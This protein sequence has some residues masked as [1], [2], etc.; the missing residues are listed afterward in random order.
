MSAQIIRTLWQRAQTQTLTDDELRELAC[1]EF[2]SLQMQCLGKAISGLGS[3]ISVDG[4]NGKRAGNFQS[5][6]D[7]SELL[8]SL[9]SIIEAQSECVTVASEAAYKLG[10]K[11]PAA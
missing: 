4:D 10:Q 9:G 11:N 3:L 5:H 2:I 8:W 6:E 1:G 7:V